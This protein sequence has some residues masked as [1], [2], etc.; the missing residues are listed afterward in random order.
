MKPVLI[1]AIFL[2]TASLSCQTAKTSLERCA[3]IDE[4]AE[5]FACYDRLAGRSPADTTKESGKVTEAAD[6]VASGA[7]V[8]VPA[9]PAATP[10]VTP[11]EAKPNAEATLGLKYN[12]IPKKDRP[13]EFKFKWTRI[14][15]DALGKWIIFLENGQVWRQTDSRRFYFLNSEH[16][17]IISRSVG[18][19][20]FLKEPEGKRRIRVKRAK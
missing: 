13:D 15:K 19:G 16:W 6:P 5:R 9:A 8:V 20:F 7:D 2:F 3:S 14:K 12:Q 11:V 1:I 18:G 10:T 17:V 4:P